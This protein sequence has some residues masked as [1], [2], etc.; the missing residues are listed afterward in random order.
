MG[1]III[2]G[3]FS[4]QSASDAILDEETFAKVY[5]EMLMAQ[6][7]YIMQ[8]DQYEDEADMRHALD[9]TEQEILKYYETDSATFQKSIIAYSKDTEAMQKILED[10]QSQLDSI[11]TVTRL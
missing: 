11:V 10:S 2:F 3:V 6:N 4:C 8:S 1:T 9:S 7:F 5:L